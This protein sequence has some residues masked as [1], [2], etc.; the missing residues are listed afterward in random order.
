MAMKVF[1]NSL[2]CKVLRVNGITLYPFVFVRSQAPG[3]ILLN[4]ERIHFEQVKRLG[5]W[6]FYFLYLKEYLSNRRRGLGHY[7]AYREISFEKEAYLF[8]DNPDEY[9]SQNYY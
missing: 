4:H 7:Q 3:K 6:R 8:Q 9:L 1:T 2:L 5:F